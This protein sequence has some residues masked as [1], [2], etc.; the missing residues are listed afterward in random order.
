MA[1]FA[2]VYIR[3]QGNCEKDSVVEDIL[4]YEEDPCKEQQS[5]G[6]PHRE[7]NKP[8][9]CASDGRSYYSPKEYACAVKKNNDWFHCK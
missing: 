5:V 8:L 3:L 1:Y 4:E 2:E 9:F 7:T 6:Q